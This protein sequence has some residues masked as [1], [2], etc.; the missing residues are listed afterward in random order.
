M[1]HRYSQVHPFTHRFTAEQRDV[2]DTAEMQRAIELDALESECFRAWR[3]IITGHNLISYQ[4]REIWRALYDMGAS[5][6][7]RARAYI[8]GAHRR[9]Y[10]WHD[11]RP[12]VTLVNAQK[13]LLDLIA[14]MKYRWAELRATEAMET[15]APAPEAA[16]VPSSQ[17]RDE[18]LPTDQ[19][20]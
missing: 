6:S 12:D 2:I 7:P 15:A 9:G 18:V 11:P 16:A 5:L 10:R 14:D 3:G 20:T 1:T 19:N 4:I 17:K 8:D 13:R